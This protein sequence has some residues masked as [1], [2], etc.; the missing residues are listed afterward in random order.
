MTAETLTIEHLTAHLPERPHEEIDNLERVIR[1]TAAYRLDRALGDLALPAEGDWCIRQ[2]RVVSRLD[3]ERPDL[4]LQDA[5]AASV[6]EAIN[7]ALRTRDAVHF[8][9]PVDALADLV[10]SVSM[11]QFERAWAWERLGLAEAREVS[12]DPAATVLAALIARPTEALAAVL[13]AVGRVG[14]APVH[15]LFGA[16]GWERLAANV[17]FAYGMSPQA[18]SLRTA[19]APGRADAHGRADA[20]GSPITGTRAVLVRLA[21][22]SRLADA[23]R[24]SRLR[25]EP[26]E[27]G[28]LAV[29][30]L[31]EVEPAALSRPGIE[32]S[33]DQATDLLTGDNPLRTIATPFPL[34]DGSS[35]E[36][37]GSPRGPTDEVRR[38]GNASGQAEPEMHTT[39]PDRAGHAGETTAWAGLL[40]L[41][42]VACDAGMPTVLFDDESL[43]GLPA[44]E[45]LARVALALV[46]AGDCDPAVRVFAGLA[47]GTAIPGWLGVQPPD[48]QQDRIVGHART[49][50]GAVAGRLDRTTEDALA[51]VAAVAAR[52]GIVDQESGWTD[53]HLDLSGVD[54]DERRAAL[55]VDPGWVSW[56]GCVVRFRYA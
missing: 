6:I 3:L 40:F 27:A 46:P 23:V 45:L 20:I 53:V 14:F 37:P 43:T 42:N 2:L 51:V 19:E 8:A 15:R 11:S 38:A 30:V 9:R 48:E 1:S 29:L 7:L 41:L 36:A 50:A 44:S 55:D 33:L 31:A 12:R 17:A 39:E 24:R 28:P 54:V 49:W 26:H 25:L 5:L 34:A 32:E 56:L 47:P 10:A 52:P 21:G 18:A 35:S 16:R 13:R 4:S 22:R